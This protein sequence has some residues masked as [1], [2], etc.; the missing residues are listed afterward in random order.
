M[1]ELRDFGTILSNVVPYRM[2]SLA[3]HYVEKELLFHVFLVTSLK[4]NAQ[5]WTPL[6]KSWPKSF[7]KRKVG[8]RK[9]VSIFS[10]CVN[11]FLSFSC[12]NM[13]G[14]SFI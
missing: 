2:E 8:R 1:K 3:A 7:D 5:H 9:L 12:F 11:C 6:P 14:G 13:F 4:M 10:K